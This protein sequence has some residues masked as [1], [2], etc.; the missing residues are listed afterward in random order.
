MIISKME[1]RPWERAMR[2]QEIAQNYY[3]ADDNAAP[4]QADAAA[5]TKGFCPQA[6]DMNF[7]TRRKGIN[8]HIT[9]PQVNAWIKS[10]V[11]KKTKKARQHAT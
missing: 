8:L 7:K 3:R 6:P 4:T 5:N 1:Q 11:T 9:N 10:R 2:G